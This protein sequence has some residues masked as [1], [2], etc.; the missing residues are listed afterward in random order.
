MPAGDPEATDSSAA[1]LLPI[2]SS[3]CAGLNDRREMGRK[4]KESFCNGESGKQTPADRELKT[5]E[6]ETT[7]KESPFKNRRKPYLRKDI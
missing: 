7:S 3:E 4:I 1:C 6:A 2:K 5:K